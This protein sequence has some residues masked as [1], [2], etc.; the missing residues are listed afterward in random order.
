[1]HPEKEDRQKERD[2]DLVFSYMTLRNLIGFSGMLLPLILY[3]FTV[4]AP[5]DNLVEPSISDY[6]YT[7]NG[8]VLVVILCSL[9]VFLFTYNGYEW[10][11]KLWTIQA[12]ICG[13]GVAFSPTVTKYSRESFSVHTSLNEVPMVFGFERHLLFAAWFFICLSIIAL[14]YFPKSDATSDVNVEGNRTSKGKRNLVYRVCG[15]TMLLCVLILA[16]YFQVSVFRN[17]MGDFP[18][19][20]VLE[21]VA[22]EAFGISWITKGET[23]WPDRDHYLAYA[24]RQIRSYF[25]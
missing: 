3:I 14:V 4:R 23:L 22:I 13:L 9:S 6:Y 19:V 25:H 5:A 18:V 8:D 12:A 21:T 20:F 15:I 11:E 24:F 2:N 17:A 1:M 7:S 10:R 16:L